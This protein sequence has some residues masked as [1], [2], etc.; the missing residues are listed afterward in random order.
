M[1]KS[2]RVVEEV[3]DNLQLGPIISYHLSKHVWLVHIVRAI[4]IALTGFPNLTGFLNEFE[5]L[6]VN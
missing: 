6:I 3:G 2:I 4:P 1:Q 5:S